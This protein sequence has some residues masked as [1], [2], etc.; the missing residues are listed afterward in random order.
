MCAPVFLFSPVEKDRFLGDYTE[1]A[2][3]PGYIKS[4]HGRDILNLSCTLDILP[5]G[6]AAPDLFPQK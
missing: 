1:L 5:E 3:D 4:L 2:P 6:H